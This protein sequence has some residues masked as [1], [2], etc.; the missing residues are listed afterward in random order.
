M[1]K[2]RLRKRKQ[3]PRI[4]REIPIR[5]MIPNLMTLLAAASGVTSIRYSCQE[6]W[7]SA[8]IAI[9]IACMLDGLDGRVAR[10]LRV[11]SKLG[12][13]LDSLADFVSFGV[14]PALLVYFWMM[15]VAPPESTAYAFRGLFWA[16]ALFHA[17]CCAFRLARFNIMLDD[18]PTQPYWKHFFMGLP[19]PGGAGILLTPVIWQL[20]TESAAIQSPWI[21]CAMLMICGILMACRAPTISAKHLR[22]PAKRMVPVLLFVMFVIGMLVSQFWLTLG[23]IGILYFTSIPICGFWYLKLRRRYQAQQAQPTAAALTHP[24]AAPSPQPTR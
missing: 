9:I 15:Q 1:G 21:G 13:Q 2:F 18:G 6:H 4:Q 11:T 20:H 7:R 3:K 16:L 22:V 24:A 17:M 19:A 23:V 14:A 12:A 10:L 5:T 8:V